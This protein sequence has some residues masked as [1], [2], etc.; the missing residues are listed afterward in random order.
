VECIRL[1]GF[2]GGFDIERPGSQATVSVLSMIT[3]VNVYEVSRL[4]STPEARN[5]FIII[6]AAAF[7]GAGGLRAWLAS[8]LGSHKVW[9]LNNEG[10]V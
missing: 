8:S 10:V 1:G 9:F 2:P 6:P 5:G 3:S 7:L 4:H